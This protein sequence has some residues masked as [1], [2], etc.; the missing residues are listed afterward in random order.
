MD[1]PGEL[2]PPELAGG[3]GEALVARAARFA[4]E[5][6]AVNLQW[7]TPSWNEGAIRFY[8]RLGTSDTNKQRFTMTPEQCAALAQEN[9]PSS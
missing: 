7:Q 1:V 3:L 4:L 6:K 8:R 2:P 9:G 5:R